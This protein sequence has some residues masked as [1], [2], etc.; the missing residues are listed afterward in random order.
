MSNPTMSDLPIDP[1]IG[2]MVSAAE[3]LIPLF[4][5]PAVDHSLARRMAVSALYAYKPET[6][7]DFLN[8]ARIIAF[9][10]AAL[11]LLGKAASSDMAMP[12]QMRAF[13]RA[14]A[15]NRSADQSE[16]TMMLRRRYD[17]A[18]PQTE[19]PPREPAP[20]D[21]QLDEAGVQAEID[22]IMKEYLAACETRAPEPTAPKAT[23]AP[24]IVKMQ[25]QAAKPASAIRYSVPLSQPAATSLKQALLQQSAMPPAVQQGGIRHTV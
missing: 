5:S 13:G 24:E 17:K 6:R 7:A 23:P 8:A 25:P 4:E 20:P 15:L 11:A 12:E 14:N 16:R 3:R 10:M 19:Q 9:S 21:T 22:G 1:Q 2:L 18:N